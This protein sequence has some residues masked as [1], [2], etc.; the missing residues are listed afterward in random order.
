MAF[1]DDQQSF[2][3]TSYTTVRA[4]TTKPVP[5]ITLSKGTDTVKATLTSWDPGNDLALLTVPRP[6]LPRPRPPKR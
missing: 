4:A 5:D 3:L 2:L 1:A 6:N